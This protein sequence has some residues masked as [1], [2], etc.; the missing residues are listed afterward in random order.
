VNILTKKQINT[1]AYILIGIALVISF[2][3]G[4]QRMNIEKDYDQVEIMVNSTELVSLANANNLEIKELAADLKDRG[5]TGVLVKEISLG[6]M[7]RTG[8]IEF[9]QG[10]E[11]KLVPY[12]ESLPQNLPL[13]DANIF[14][15]IHDKELEEQIVKHLDNKMPGVKYYPGE[16]PVVVVPINIPNSDKEKESIYEDLKSI[17]VGFDLDSLNEIASLGIKVIPQVR[18]W[19]KPTEESLKF[20]AEEI[21]NIPNLSFI[22]FNDKQIP[23]YPDKIKLLVDE[24]KNSQG[25]VYAPVG[26]VEFFNQKGITQ[27]ATYMNKE[28]VR[29][30]SIALNDMV[31]YNPEKAIDRFE[32]AVSERNI[33]ALFVRFFDMEQ[34]AA[35]LEN[36][37]NYLEDLK[38]ALEKQGYTVGQVE[39]FNSPVYSRILIGLIGLGVIAGGILILTKKD[40]LFIAIVL[41][42]L[43]VIAWGGLLYKNP[44]MARKLMALASVIIFPTLAFLV[45]MKEKKRNL[46]DSIISLLKMSA[47]SLI[48]ALLMVG[49]LADKLFM[50]KLDQFIGVKAAHIIP[51]LLIP[52]LLHTFNEKPVVTV[53]RILNQAITYK[54]VLLAS[55]ALLALAVYVIR[56]GND[57]TALVTSLEEQIRAG[58]KEILGVRPRTK[59]F[60]IGHPFTLILLYFGVSTRNWILLLP[61]I[62]ILLLPAIIGQVSL[63]NTYAHIHTPLIISIIRS[64]HGLWMGIII[65]IILIYAWKIAE[66]YL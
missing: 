12:A 53:K 48:G 29:V 5:V 50:L 45:V 19:P 9:F 3:L 16:I 20:I 60:L 63:V 6:D 33:R 46:L 42:A 59:E 62:W 13:S 1:I 65:G 36:N 64:F 66:K 27:F 49:L 21:K 28:T 61:A 39:Q 51:L 30:H 54:Y 18:D 26:T 25:E 22:M 43:G 7:A 34:P 32:L 8:Q 58:L 44:L 57:G 11:V 35:A 31:N 47:L 15:P 24:F 14:I 56:T 52:L 10:Q 40:W 17:G 41:G 37:L 4:V 23:G 55:I 2:Y 38:A